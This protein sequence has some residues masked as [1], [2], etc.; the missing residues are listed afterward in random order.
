MLLYSCTTPPQ[1][2]TTTPRWWLPSLFF[3]LGKTRVSGFDSGR[4]HSRVGNISPVESQVVGGIGVAMRRRLISG[5]LSFILGD[6][7]GK[8]IRDM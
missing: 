4:V 2:P 7:C 6:T 8:G 3:M 1:T 5:V